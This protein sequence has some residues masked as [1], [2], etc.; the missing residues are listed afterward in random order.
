MPPPT[1]GRRSALARTAGP[2]A[3][4]GIGLGAR[5]RSRSRSRSLRCVFLDGVDR[6]LG[7]ALLVA[8]ATR[9]NAR[10]RGLLPAGDRRARDRGLARD[11]EV[12]LERDELVVGERAEIARLDVL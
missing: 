8:G 7:A 5:V 12:L 10:A 4:T 6:R 2:A 9:D 3:R 1:R 11:A